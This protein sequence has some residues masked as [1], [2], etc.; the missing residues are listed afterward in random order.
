MRHFPEH[1]CVDVLESTRCEVRE[2]IEC[3]PSHQ[4]AVQLAYH[5]GFANIMIA[6]K[7]FGQFASKRHRLFSGYRCNDA[8]ASV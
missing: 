6:R 5:V 3:R 8:H 7:G 4:L 1:D 2:L